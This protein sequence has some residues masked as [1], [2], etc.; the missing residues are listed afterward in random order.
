MT[1]QSNAQKRGMYAKELGMG[2]ESQYVGDNE[3]IIANLLV[4]SSYFSFFQ[5]CKHWVRGPAAHH[6]GGEYELFS[7]FLIQAS[8]SFRKA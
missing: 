8:F 6:S 3:E 1:K 5:F 2:I 7:S 4:L